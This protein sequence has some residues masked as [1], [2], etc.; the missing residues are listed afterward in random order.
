MVLKEMTLLSGT[1]VGSPAEP[2][3]EA[4][5]LPLAHGRQ[6]E[7][8]PKRRGQAPGDRW[9]ARPVVANEQ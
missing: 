9:F 5:G 4:A 2:V 8:N 7:G 6:L 1:Y 3:S